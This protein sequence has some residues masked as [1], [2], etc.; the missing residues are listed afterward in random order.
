MNPSR[1]DMVLRLRQ[2]GISDNNVLRAMETIPRAAFI[3][4]QYSGIAYDERVIPIECG[5]S[6]PEPLTVAVMAQALGLNGQGK[7]LEIGSGSG[8]QAAVLS[9]LCT[10]VYSV[11][12]YRALSGI[13]KANC[14][15]HSAGN[16]VFRHGDGRFGWRG[17]APFDAILVT[18]GLKVKPLA[19]MGQ[20]APGGV[21]VC[22]LDGMLTALSTA[23][24]PRDYFPVKI[25]PIEAGKS[26][27]L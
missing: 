26:K 19:L 9:H 5:Q 17:Q 3:D 25:A 15:D 8:Y 23:K 14:A 13:A 11:E 2:A 4:R 22:V 10:R 21:L 20:L 27:A 18:A 7:V 12:R 16:V 1:L 24:P 6:L